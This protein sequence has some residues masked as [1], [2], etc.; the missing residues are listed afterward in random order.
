MNIYPS[1]VIGLGH[2]GKKVTDAL[3][4]SIAFRTDDFPA[5]DII[6]YPGDLLAAYPQKEKKETNSETPP[7]DQEGNWR[8]EER[9]KFIQSV[10]EFSK[11]LDKSIQTVMGF[12]AEKGIRNLF[13]EWPVTRMQSLNIYIT[14]AICETVCSGVFLDMAYF[15][16]HHLR[17]RHGMKG[18]RVEGIFILTPELSDGEPAASGEKEKKAAHI[19]A[20]L[21]ELDYHFESRNFS[22]DYL[23]P[24]PVPLHD[25]PF[26]HCY[27]LD[28]VK[29]NRST[30]PDPDSLNPLIG[31][32]LFHLIFPPMSEK[33][34]N[35]LTN[36]VLSGYFLD[37]KITAYSGIGIASIS[38]PRK[39][40]LVGAACRYAG[41]IVRFGLLSPEPL[42]SE[43]TEEVEDFERKNGVTG[44]AFLEVLEDDIQEKNALDKAKDEIV[45]LTDIEHMS[46]S[47]WYNIATL[48]DIEKKVE[49]LKRKFEDQWQERIKED[50]YN[51]VRKLEEKV[52]QRKLELLHSNRPDRQDR[53][54]EFAFL[55]LKKLKEKIE[56]SHVGIIEKKRNEH[57]EEAQQLGRVQEVKRSRLTDWYETIP[58]K[59]Q[60]F[61]GSTFLFLFS[62]LI[63]ILAFSLYP[64][65]IPIAVPLLGC[66]EI[67]L[68]TSVFI[69]L[70]T[71]TIRLRDEIF[72]DIREWFLEQVSEFR[73]MNDLELIKNFVPEVLDKKID[74]LDGF[75]TN[76]KQVEGDLQK[77]EELALS[78]L[79]EQ[80]SFITDESILS[81]DDLKKIYNNDKELGIPSSANRNP[82]NLEDS[83][84]LDA[85]LEKTEDWL[86]RRFKK[87][88]QEKVNRSTL[89]KL[90][91]ENLI[92]E[93]LPDT[94]SLITK[95]GQILEDSSPLVSHGDMELPIDNIQ[96]RTIFGYYSGSAPKIEEVF[97]QLP[98][99]I[100]SV[101]TRQRDQ[102][103]AISISHGFPLCDINHLY[104][105]KSEYEAV[106]VEAK[107][108]L[109]IFE[110]LE[111]DKY[112]VRYIKDLHEIE[113]E[114]LCGVALCLGFIY[115]KEDVSKENEKAAYVF[116][117]PDKIMLEGE[118][119]QG[120]ILPLSLEPILSSEAILKRLDEEIKKMVDEV[121]SKEIA[122]MLHQGLQKYPLTRIMRKGVKYYLDKLGVNL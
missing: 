76:L 52:T 80:R 32:I 15:C 46:F 40:M 56:K 116:K 113:V 81:W 78:K 49:Q 79:L 103:L 89:F 44:E 24:K 121:K 109:H 62:V 34:I 11:L 61:V 96:H 86:K 73:Y 54:V 72:Q 21:K 77:E 9:N 27:L 7:S 36:D 2:A 67:V 31:E 8:L 13:T 42:E 37:Q 118:L 88:A 38:F 26:D 55:F 57:K 93:K 66:L 47:N 75:L 99:E 48:T 100:D 18:C 87:I 117:E 41:E 85:W 4:D 92:N 65:K 98:C 53:S 43:V 63:S 122:R 119:L 68:V 83:E 105:F 95:L 106:P 82:R 58:T 111:N 97:R 91:V 70:H 101:S 25:R 17:K 5:V 59:K 10:Q 60:I 29:R 23:T 102:F 74:Q 50:R 84:T 108:G 114:R 112:D 1:I 22:L 94:T 64:L 6:I 33:M 30:L 71:K 16:R 39:D 20:A 35:P 12:E 104:F 120:S 107:K 14:G 90:K 3:K 51:K 45:G 19:Y 69:W 115:W 28:T 110:D